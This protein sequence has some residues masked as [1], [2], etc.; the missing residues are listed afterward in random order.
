[1]S[2]RRKKRARRL[3]ASRRRAVVSSLTGQAELRG[4]NMLL[5]SLEQRLVLSATPLFSGE[6]A[7]GPLGLSLR[8]EGNGENQRLVLYD[9]LDSQAVASIP[10][11]D[12]V[13]GVTIEGSGYNDTL[14]V[15]LEP[16]WVRELLP[17]GISF[18]GGLGDD[19]LQGPGN[20]TV[21]NIT[22]ANSGNIGG[23]LGIQ[24]SDVEFLS[25]S[26]GNEDTFVVSAAGG[27]SGGL[28]GGDGGYDTLVIDGGNFTEVLYHTSGPDSGTVLR[29]GNVIRYAGLEPVTD[30]TASSVKTVSGTS[31]AD[32]ITIDSVGIDVPMLK[33]LNPLID[34]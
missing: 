30:N 9:D 10:V 3:R 20:D 26:A 15:D 27:L 28:H 5:E 1:M 31:G 32:V 24:F 29:D 6:D 12:V 7:A 16:A 19:S 14:T 33:I 2:S 22:G 21:W 25:G 18:D 23:S 17:A 8:A 11:T 34:R 4:R 13:D